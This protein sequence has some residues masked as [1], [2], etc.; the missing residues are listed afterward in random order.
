MKKKSALAS[1]VE[2]SKKNAKLPDKAPKKEK[3]KK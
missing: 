3:Y 2:G 1:F